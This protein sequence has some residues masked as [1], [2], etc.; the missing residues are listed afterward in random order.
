[1]ESD[2]SPTEAL[3]QWAGLGWSG[4]GS[5]ARGSSPGQMAIFGVDCSAYSHPSSCLPNPKRL[6]V[7]QG[8]EQWEKSLALLQGGSGV[9]L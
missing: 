4:G 3:G 6:W 7:Q 9:S 5:G 2:R 1:M 8:Q